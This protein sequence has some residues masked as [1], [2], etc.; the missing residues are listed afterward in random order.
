MAKKLTKKRKAVEG[1]VDPDKLYA[2]TDAMTLVK[3]VNT[4]NF[5]ASVDVHVRQLRRK[6]GDGSIETIRGG[7]YRMVSRA[8]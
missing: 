4:T 8:Q 7:G 2:L 5:N 1:K 3:E 6:L